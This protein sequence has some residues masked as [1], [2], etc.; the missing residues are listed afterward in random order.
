M[1]GDEG[2]IAKL[3]SHFPE[4]VIG[5]N[6]KQEVIPS[7]LLPVRN[8]VIL[9]DHSLLDTVMRVLTHHLFAAVLF[10]QSGVTD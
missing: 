8:P 6:V 10:L 4:L 7:G 3:K 9:P 5:V 1:F 2:S